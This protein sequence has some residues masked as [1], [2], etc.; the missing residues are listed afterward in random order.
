MCFSVLHSELMH[1][2]HV[3]PLLRSLTFVILLKSFN[4]ALQIV[5]YLLPEMEN[6][7]GKLVVVLA[8]YKVR[9]NLSICQSKI[10]IAKVSFLIQKTIMFMLHALSLPCRRQW[11]I[12]LPSTRAFPVDFLFHS[13]STTT[14]TRSCLPC[15]N[16]VLIVVSW[17]FT[18]VPY[19]L[20]TCTLFFVLL[21]KLS[22]LTAHTIL[23]TLVLAPVCHR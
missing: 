19:S 4:L 11:K 17:R 7:R 16:H 22:P 13:H 18:N 2:F 8:G 20:S 12:C 1:R 15:C 3:A 14:Q 10:G 5:N 6:R 21:L 23:I 9:R